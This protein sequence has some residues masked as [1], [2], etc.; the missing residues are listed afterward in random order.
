MKKYFN[1]ASTQIEI[2]TILQIVAADFLSD[3]F[4]ILPARKGGSANH[5]I[6]PIINDITILINIIWIDA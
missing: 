4:L 3:F 2:P 1:T 5:I 6:N